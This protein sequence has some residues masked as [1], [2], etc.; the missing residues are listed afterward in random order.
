MIQAASIC[1]E[2]G[3][4]VFREFITHEKDDENDLPSYKGP[5]WECKFVLVDAA[6]DIDALAFATM[7]SVRSSP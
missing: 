2:K 4:K 3:A 5:P 7:L 1:A 6:D